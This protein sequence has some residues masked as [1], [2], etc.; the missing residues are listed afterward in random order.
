[1]CKCLPALSF[2][3]CRQCFL[4]YNFLNTFSGR[5]CCTGQHLL[6]NIRYYLQKDG[7]AQKV[8]PLNGY[9]ESKCT[10]ALL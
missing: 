9:F 5:M 1:M 3:E 8:Q 7:R 4:Y 2:F 6:K 10:S